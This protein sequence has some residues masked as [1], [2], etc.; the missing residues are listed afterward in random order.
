MKQKLGKKFWVALVVFSLIG[1]VAWVVENMYFNVFIYKIFHASAG[2]ISRMVAFSAVTATVT[3]LLI[4]ALSDKI[5]KRKVFICVGYI[6]WGISILSFCFLRME[7]LQKV[8]GSLAAAAS[9]G[10]SLV[11]LL[12]CVMTFFGSSA[13]D[14][15][16]NA[17]LTESGNETNRGAIE[18][19]NAMM[20][21]VSIL[22]V[23]GGFMAFNLE[24]SES[25][26]VI[27][28]LIGCV[29]LLIGFL[30]FFLIE[31]TQVE[32]QENQDYFKNILYSFRPTI[33]R[34]NK[35]LYTVVAAYAVFGISIQIFMPYLI[36]YYEKSLGMNHYVL[37][38]A[39]AII[40]AAAI[41][42]GYGK[43]YDSLGFRRSIYPTVFMLMAGYVLLFFF[44][45]TAPVFLGSLLMM[46]GYL[47]GMAIFGAKI[48][49]HT[50]E[51]KAGLFQ[52]LRIFGQVFIPG[53]VGPAVGAMV[54]KNAAK[55]VNGDGT[56]SFLPNQNIFLA[57]LL[58]AGLLMVILKIIFRMVR[59]GHRLLPTDL[60]DGKEIPF[61]EYPRPQFRRESWYNLNGVWNNEILVP[62]PP[63][64]QLSGFGKRVG[65]QLVYERGFTLPEGFV[66]D[67]I[68]LH[69]GAVDQKAEVFINGQSVG[70]HEG[71]YLPFSFDITESYKP[72][73]NT[74]MVK[75][76]DHL[77]SYL[78]YGK[79]RRKRGE[80][81]YTP[82][83]GIWQTV[84]IESVPEDYVEAIRITPDLKGILLEVET[85]A[86]SYEVVI[87]TPEKEVRKK[88]TAPSLR[89][90]LMQEGCNPIL[91]TPE[92]PYLYDIS[93]STKRDRVESYFALRTVEIL[94]VGG[95]TRICLNEKPVFIHGVLDQGYFSDG[96]YLPASEK[97]YEFD[98][99]SMKELGFNTLRKHI[100][101][102]PESFYYLCDKLGMLVL[103]DMVNNGRYSF[104]RDTALPTLGFLRRKDNCRLLGKRRKKVFEDHMLET[105]K[106]LYNHPCII[107]YTIF[108]EG[109]GQFD[110]DRMYE[111]LRAADATRIV[112][113][114]S[115]WFAHE[116]SDVDSRHVYFN[117]FP[118]V[119]G[120]RPLVLSE[121]G[122]Y[123]YVME[124]HSYSLY[125]QHGYGFFKDEDTLTEKILEAYREMVFSSLE[126][127]LC[128]SIY[129]QLSDV[130]DEVNGLYTY[131]RKCCKVKKEAMQKL[132]E[133]LYRTYEYI[134]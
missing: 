85:K 98:I 13:N 32:R 42:A 84:W 58:V 8:T 129:T 109:W 41:T 100:K 49:D 50:P 90:D 99:R 92:Q 37:I 97:G 47:T 134:L 128:G 30:G 45:S 110:S 33:I 4:G 126:Q 70:A 7:L 26:T 29:V 73:E 76:T 9:L 67:K 40:L 43:L 102:E 64:S 114:T 36:L 2:D 94:E 52:G 68:L 10:V 25:W 124:E 60:G 72:G 101:V 74:L 62:Y 34:Q 46:T 96:I 19:I 123:S 48:R 55:V 21:L 27:F 61:S 111:V 89:I 18:G 86:E 11:I 107:Y 132:A 91:W 39:P 22:V 78:P 14:A 28:L 66:R 116:K 79:Q 95:R 16:F 105:V 3:T 69:F 63:Q 88:S 1:Q 108:N 133:D 17:W 20:P 38:M 115:G 54:L 44:R 6:A 103:Q 131:D 24:K 5:G 75:V 23:F 71:G 77:S 81:W 57:A 31:D 35:M 12:D 15:C 51:N 118:L 87:Q 53:V 80:M 59:K 121:F 112:D 83:S 113:T 120:M 106:T 56:E 82:V 117:A 122:G 93:I 104:L 127:G 125:Y 65:R 130:E 119:G